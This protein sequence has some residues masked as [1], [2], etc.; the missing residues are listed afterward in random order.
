MWQALMRI[1]LPILSVYNG[2]RSWRW[3]PSQIPDELRSAYTM[4]GKIPVVRWYLNDIR[5]GGLTWTT[6]SW[7]WSPEK[8]R[9]RGTAYY[10]KTDKYLYEALDAHSIRDKQLVIVGSEFP[11]YECIA[12]SYGAAVTTIEY[13]QVHCR[14]PGLTVVT[15]TEF[16]AH[17][18]KFDVALSIS[19]IEHD[20]LGRYGDPLNPTGDLRAMDEFRSLLEPDGFLLLAV[21]VGLDALVWN[22]HRVYGHERLPRL[23]AG[24]R[25]IASYG[26][27]ESLL[28]QGPLGSFANQPVF[29]LQPV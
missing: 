24:W 17:P 7:W 13:R 11:W 8:V 29:V 12:T 1:W 18:R 6:K 2:I 21:P 10:G 27:N 28:D 14:I 5:T 26:Y 15:P 3:P 25:I 19:S 4:E 20:G 23:L 22:A 9:R 16:Q